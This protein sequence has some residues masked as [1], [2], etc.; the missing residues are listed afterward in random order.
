MK[1]IVLFLLLL[2]ACSDLLDARNYR[3][4]KVTWTCVSPAGCQ[5]ADQV[6]LIDRAQ[7]I[8]GNETVTFLSTHDGSFRDSAQM[9]PSDDLPAGCFWL[10]D[11]AFFVIELEPAKF[12]PTSGGFEVEL[13]IPDRDAATYSEWLIEGREIDP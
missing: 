8:N 7:I 12:C 10:Y 13:S 6:V 11:V 3:T 9:L 1:P 2:S 4:Y 5:R